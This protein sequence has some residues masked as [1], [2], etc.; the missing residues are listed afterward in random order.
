MDR[1]IVENKEISGLYDS[2]ARMKSFCEFIPNNKP[3]E[4]GLAVEK[5]CSKSTSFDLSA[6][7]VV[8]IMDKR[9]ER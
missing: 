2:Y 6:K 4:F 5:Y 1:F 9:I 8:Q 3:S 7:N